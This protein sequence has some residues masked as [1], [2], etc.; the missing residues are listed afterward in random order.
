MR[1]SPTA[2]RRKDCAI[3][4]RSLHAVA[5]AQRTNE[6]NRGNWVSESIARNIWW[7]WIR[8]AG[9]CACVCQ[10]IQK[11]IVYDYG[12]YDFFFVGWW[13]MRVYKGN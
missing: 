7:I 3:I 5:D 6:R 1:S 13:K 11:V 12:P 10:P 4:A 2:Q 8:N 9:V